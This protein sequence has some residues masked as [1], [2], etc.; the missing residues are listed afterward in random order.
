M[1]VSRD[2]RRT[3]TERR[4]RFETLR[5]AQARRSNRVSVARLAAFLIA[6]ACGVA[7]EIRPGPLFVIAGLGFLI[8]FV[9]LVI[10]HGGIRRRERWLADLRDFNGEGLHRLDRDWASLPARPLPL[11][12]QHGIAAD[13]DVF[14]RPAL[15]Q[16]LGPTGTPRG[17]ETCARWLLDG[18][19]PAEIAARQEAVKELA[20][21]NDVRESL[22]VHGRAAGN[23]SS[24]DIA[25]FLAWAEGAPLMQGRKLV[26][27]L[28]FA[29]PAATIL[30][31]VLGAAGIVPG[32]LWI[33][34]VIVASALTARPGKQVRH[35]FEH[36][37]G[38]EGMFRGYPDMFAIMGTMSPTSAR[39]SQLQLSLGE[40]EASAAVCMARLARLMHLAD[41]RHSGLTHVIVQLLLLWDFH[42]HRA[43]ERCPPWPRS[44]TIIRRGAL[45]KSMAAQRECSR[46]KGL[47]MQCCPRK[48]GSITT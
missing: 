34:P 35:A 26:Q 19:Q 7:A 30:T 13:L 29:V 5:A 45:P 23:V 15:T 2:P 37:F 14:G 31:I 20:P 42:V 1:P 18:A 25:A 10:H 41:L 40:G 16:L 6:L 33:L 32:T 17:R 47:V 46:R 28:S 3:Y 21:E 48:D 44:H 39:L 27:V 9:A 22:A 4:D 11:E 24:A 36:A 8:A 43:V 12:D 38:R